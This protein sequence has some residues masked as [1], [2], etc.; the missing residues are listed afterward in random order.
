MQPLYDLDRMAR[1]VEEVRVAERDVLRARLDK[2][3]DFCLDHITLHHAEL[4]L[5]H[6]HYRAMPTHVLTA[7]C[8][9]SVPDDA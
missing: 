7:T 6:R 2:V 8:R 5:I 4:A 3:G 1:A 9:L